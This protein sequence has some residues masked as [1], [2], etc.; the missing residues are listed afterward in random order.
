MARLRL[1]LALL[2]AG[3]AAVGLSAC[4]GGDPTADIQAG[5]Q[6]FVSACG[7]CHA[8]ADARTRGQPQFPNLDDAFRGARQQGWKDSQFRGVV[9]RWIEISQPPMPRNLV[10]GQDAENV[11]AYVAQV[12][13]HTSDSVV[14]TPAAT[15]TEATTAA[16]PPAQGAAPGRVVVEADPG[17]DLAWTRNML[18]A[19]A[20]RTTFEMRNPSQVPHNLAIRNGVQAGPS[21]T[22]TGGNATLRVEL[23]A[24]TYT[25]YCAVPGHEQAGMRGTLT[26]D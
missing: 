18:R 15:T 12:A 7:G 17:G 19:R 3:G 23:D 25:Y 21:Q 22:V 5:R 1:G 9:K 26:V 14:T 6:R 11:A 4:G 24:G 13:G 10:T 8:L 16:P 20:G 2:A